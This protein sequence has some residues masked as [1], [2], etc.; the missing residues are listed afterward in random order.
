MPAG[1][2]FGPQDSNLTIQSYPGEQPW[3][4]RGVPLTGVNWK[5][6]NTSGGGWRV[7]QNENNVFGEVPAPGVVYNTTYTT[8]QACQAACQANATSGGVCTSFTWHDANTGQYALQC[9]FRIDGVWN[10]TAEADHVSG[11]VQVMIVVAVG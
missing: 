7:F 4:S 6:Y 2:Q 9:Y 8:W 5:P 1:V 11:Y 3:L 10:P